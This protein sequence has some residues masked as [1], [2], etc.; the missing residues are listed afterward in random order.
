MTRIVACLLTRPIITIKYPINTGV[1]TSK[2]AS[3]HI[4]TTIHRQKSAITKLVLGVAIKPEINNRIMLNVAYS[5]Q[6]GNAHGCFNFITGFT[7]LYKVIAQIINTIPRIICHS[8]PI[9]TY[10][11]PWC[12]NQYQ[13]FPMRPLGPS[14]IPA[15]DPAT[16]T[17][18]SQKI[19]LIKTTCFLDCPG[20]T[21][22]IIKNDAPIQQA[23]IHSSDNCTCQLLVTVIGNASEILNPKK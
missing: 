19:V 23:D 1:N 17:T 10:S 4:C 7:P 12:P 20:E 16:N 21:I 18:V 3:A 8:F 14:K 11:H 5:N 22:D 9:S 15:K 6:F 13:F 2:K